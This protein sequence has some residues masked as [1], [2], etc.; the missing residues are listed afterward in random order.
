LAGTLPASGITPL[1]SPVPPDE[2]YCTDMP[3][4]SIAAAVGLWSSTKS[5]L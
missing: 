5:W 3:D 2:R 1:G 4:T